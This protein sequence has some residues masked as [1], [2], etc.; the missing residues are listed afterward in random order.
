MTLPQLPNKTGPQVVLLAAGIVAA[1]LARDL[2]VSRQA[3]SQWLRGDEP[4]N[5]DRQTELVNAL[6]RRLERKLDDD[7]ATYLANH[8]AHQL[9][10]LQPIEAASD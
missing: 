6:R 3:M 8:F 5:T 7:A 1:D 4:V 2:N 9:A 10:A